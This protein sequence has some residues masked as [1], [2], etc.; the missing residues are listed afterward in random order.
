MACACGSLS[1]DG[2]A[3]S[4][5]ENK[6]ALGLGHSEE[7]NRSKP[8]QTSI[9]NIS[10]ISAGSL[11]ENNKG[12]IFSCGYNESGGC[13]LGHFNSPQITPSLIPNH[14]QTLFILFVEITIAYFLI[15][16]EMYFL[17]GIMRKGQLG[18]GHITNQNILNMIPNIPPIKI[19]SCVGSSC[20]LIDFEGNL[21]NQI[22]GRKRN[23][24]ISI[25][26]NVCFLPRGIF[27]HNICIFAWMAKAKKIGQ[28][29]DLTFKS[30]KNKF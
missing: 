13:G 25:N 27:V 1:N 21:W 4:F 15:Q 10:K 5:G 20:Y 28:L 23:Y 14:F 29:I 8:Q 30:I 19:I 16:K 7:E 22:L 9:S 17:L 24:S 26:Q 3:H 11:F 2:T 6:G 12:E 18:L